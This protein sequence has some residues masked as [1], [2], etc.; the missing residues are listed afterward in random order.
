M[1]AQFGGV[2]FGATSPA[3]TVAGSTKSEL[4]GDIVGATGLTVT[5]TSDNDASAT[6]IVISFGVMTNSSGLADANVTS[7][8]STEALVGST[9]SLTGP[10]WRRAG[11]SDLRR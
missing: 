9:A 11:G 4:N 5:S 7:E 3:A 6:A 8:A 10:W 1:R 2:G